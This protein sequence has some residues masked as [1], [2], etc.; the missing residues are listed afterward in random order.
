VIRKRPDAG[1]CATCR[2]A[3][4]QT[5]A[6]GSVFWRCLRAETD[7]RFARYPRLPVHACAGYERGMPAESDG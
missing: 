6:R 5:A 1:L 4:V 7:P 2:H 3:R